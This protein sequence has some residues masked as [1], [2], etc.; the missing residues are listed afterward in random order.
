MSK[1]CIHFL[2]HSVYNMYVC[3]CVCV[4]IYIY[5]YIYIYTHTHTHIYTHTY[6]Y[7]LLN[8]EVVEPQAGKV[9]LCRYNCRLFS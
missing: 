9:G 4:Y 2:G 5:I 7:S 3:V 1:E 8:V 6:T